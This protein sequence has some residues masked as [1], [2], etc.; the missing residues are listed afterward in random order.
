MRL[1]AIAVALVALSAPLDAQTADTGKVAQL[2]YPRFG[3]TLSLPA[4]S[5]KQSVTIPPGQDIFIE[6]FTGGGMAFAVFIAPGKDGVPPTVLVE[7]ALM[8]MS[9]QAPQTALRRWN[10]S[11][12]QSLV[13]NG[14]TFTIPREAVQMAQEG[15]IKQAIGAG[16]GVQ[17]GAVVAMPGSS[18]YALGVVALGPKSNEMAVEN[19]ARYMATTV[20]FPAIKTD[21][22]PTASAGAAVAYEW[23]VLQA[24]EIA[25]GGVVD[26]ISA[27][28]KRLSF[29]VDHVV[30][31]GQKPAKLS[32][33]RA[34]TVLASRLADFVKPGARIV[35]SGK[36]TGQGKPITATRI[37]PASSPTGPRPTAGQP[38]APGAKP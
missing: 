33:A 26:T 23:P 30:A 28:R 5:E 38:A 20:D 6:A 13:F 36:N 11:S 22:P 10:A 12:K 37:A 14:F 9:M 29:L 17:S 7:Q 32:P 35:V 27:D 21:R 24:G 19:A 1:T 18:K 4:A 8:M 31:Y 2:Q 16:M 15:W 34:K 25:L 3:L